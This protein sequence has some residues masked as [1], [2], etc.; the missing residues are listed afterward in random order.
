[1]PVN[2]NKIYLREETQIQNADIVPILFPIIICYDYILFYIYKI[3]QLLLKTR[4]LKN[5]FA[6]LGDIFKY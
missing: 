3:S 4:L 5:T 2:A 1:M 6:F